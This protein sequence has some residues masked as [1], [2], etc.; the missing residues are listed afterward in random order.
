MGIQY[1]GQSSINSG[2]GS[3]SSIS[4]TSLTGGIASSPSQG[5]LVVICI[6]NNKTGTGAP[7]VPTI[8][9]SGYTI[10][11]SIYVNDT[12][13]VQC[14]VAYKIMTATPDTSVTFAN[15][16]NS[17]GAIAMINVWR[18]VDLTTPID[19]PDVKVES[20]NTTVPAPGSITPITSGA[21]VCVLGV[22]SYGNNDYQI[23]SISSG[24]TLTAITSG[25]AGGVTPRAS[26]AI[27]HKT[28]SG[29]TETPGA[30]STLGTAGSASAG[31]LTFALRPAK[32]N[33]LPIMHMMQVAGGLV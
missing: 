30:F 14:T 27:G 32:E 6:N 5:D 28:W 20:P 25:N 10:L 1:V 33:F 24:Y 17:R 12:N 9:R 26:G 21:I 2:S 4:L 8:T 15:I 23:I 18:G 31:A 19:V 7:S 22:A 29:G 16:D 3:I 13:E 11:D